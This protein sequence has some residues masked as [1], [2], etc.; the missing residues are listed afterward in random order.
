MEKIPCE[1]CGEKTS[2]KYGLCLDCKKTLV[3]LQRDISLAAKHHKMID[4]YGQSGYNI[5]QT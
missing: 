2:D 5:N 4:E 3:A 1:R